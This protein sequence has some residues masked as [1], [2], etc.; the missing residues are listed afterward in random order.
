MKDWQDEIFTAW[1]TTVQE[2]EK[3][4]KN[5]T[6]WV[7]TVTDEVTEEIVETVDS[8][9]EELDNYLPREIEEFFWD[10]FQPFIDIEN[11]WRRGDEDNDN[12][13]NPFGEFY[14]NPKIEPSAEF[15]PACIGCSNYHGRVY[16]GNILICGIHP[17]GWETETCPDW[18]ENE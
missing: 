12:A 11:D 1:E 5:L 14:W 16:N 8:I 13:D 10:V 6:E 3:L 18:M 9:A 17:F 15:H 4:S 2:L 7:E